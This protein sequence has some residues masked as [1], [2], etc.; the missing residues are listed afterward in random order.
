MIRFIPGT[1]NI[2]NKVKNKDEFQEFYDRVVEVMKWISG[3]PRVTL[4]FNWHEYLCQLN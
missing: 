2:A 3:I 4:K 1:E